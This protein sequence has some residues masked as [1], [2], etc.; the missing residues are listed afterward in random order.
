MIILLNIVGY[1]IFIAFL[2]KVVL[3]YKYLKSSHSVEEN[4]SSRFGSLSKN[5]LRRYFLI[6]VLQ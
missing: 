4:I 5:Q 2:L 1:G 6:L 3:H